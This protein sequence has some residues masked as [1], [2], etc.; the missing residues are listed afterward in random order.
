MLV[1]SAPRLTSITGIG[2]ESSPLGL[3]SRLWALAQ[4]SGSIVQGPKSSGVLFFS[5]I[6]PLGV[7]K[8]WRKLG[9]IPWVFG[10]DPSN[11]PAIVTL[12]TE[13]DGFFL[14]LTF[15]KALNDDQGPTREDS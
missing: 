13:T 1:L 3:Q 10:Q 15:S 4:A 5:A 12:G 2:W 11:G 9:W 7:P 8:G 14:S 6:A